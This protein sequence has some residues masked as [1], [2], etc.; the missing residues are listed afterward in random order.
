MSNVFIIFVFIF[1]IVFVCFYTV[2]IVAN[3]INEWFGTVLVHCL[4]EVAMIVI[5]RSMKIVCYWLILVTSV[6]SRSIVTFTYICYSPSLTF[7]SPYRWVWLLA[8]C[9]HW[10][11]AWSYPALFLFTLFIYWSYHSPL[12]ALR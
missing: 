5:V 4:I 6:T 10:S 2:T 12:I 9:T 11:P 1:N 8:N 7:T 3:I